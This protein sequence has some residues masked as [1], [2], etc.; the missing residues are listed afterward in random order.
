[1]ALLIGVLLAVAVGLFATG[2]GLDRDRAFYPAVVIVV[3]SYYVLFAVMGAPAHTL[4]PEL[5][6]GAAFIAAAA[7]GFRLS[8]WIVVLAL[9]GHSAFDF[10]HDAI[11]ANAGVPSWWPQFC[12]AYDFTAAAYLAWLI[13]SRRVRAAP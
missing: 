13:K 2:V 4:V 8:L 1:M 11:I 10:T 9:A 12:L 5:I 6:A 7:A 3:A